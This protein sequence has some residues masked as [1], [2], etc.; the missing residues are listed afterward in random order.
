VNF[1]R[2]K[3][4]KAFGQKSDIK[5]GGSKKKYTNRQTRKSLLVKKIKFPKGSVMKAEKRVLGGIKKREKEGYWEKGVT[6][7]KQGKRKAG[8]ATVEPFPKNH[9]GKR[10]GRPKINIVKRRKPWHTK[11]KNLTFTKEREGRARK[12]LLQTPMRQDYLPSTMPC[13]KES[14]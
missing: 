4:R 5:K 14:E 8:H 1:R 10:F 11:K 7:E 13:S 2:R 6:E 9:C 3:E 12:A